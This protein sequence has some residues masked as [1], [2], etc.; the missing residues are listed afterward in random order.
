MSDH[1]SE[2]GKQDNQRVS[3][4]R[5]ETKLN[6]PRHSAE[7]EAVATCLKPV[8]I[9]KA[10]F[11]LVMDRQSPRLCALF[12]RETGEILKRLATV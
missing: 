11:S 2:E 9:V 7:S 8:I 1:Q 4:T 6:H 3:H 10:E 5:A 12:L